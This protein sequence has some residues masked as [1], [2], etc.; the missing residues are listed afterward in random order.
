VLV[1][2]KSKAITG[3]QSE[4]LKSAVKGKRLPDVEADLALYLR[5]GSGDLAATVDGAAVAWRGYLGVG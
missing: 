4:A 1:G 5:T 2:A 3:A